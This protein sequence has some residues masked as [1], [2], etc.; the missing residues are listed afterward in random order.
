MSDLSLVINISASVISWSLHWS[1][2]CF[3]LS[4]RQGKYKVPLEGRIKGG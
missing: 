2:K 4:G 1:S 3:V